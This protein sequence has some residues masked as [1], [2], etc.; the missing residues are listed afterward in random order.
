MN[1]VNLKVVILVVGLGMYMLLV[2]KVILKEMLLIVDKL[3][4]QYI[5]DEI[6]VVGIK[7]IVLVMYFLKNEVENYFDI[8]YELEVLLEQCVKCQLLVEV[9]VI[10]LLGVI[11]MNVCQ[12]QLLGL[13]YFIFCVCLVVG[14][15]LF[16][17]V[18]LDIIFDGGIVDLLCYNFVVMIVCFNEIGCSQVLVKCMLGDFFEY[19]VIQIKELMVV[20]GQVVCIVEFIEKLDELQILDFDLMVVGCYVL[21]VDIWVE[22][23]CIELGVWGCIQ[24]IDV[25]VELVKKQF[26]DVMLMIGES[27]DCGK[28]M[29]YM[30]VFVIY[31][32]CNLKEGIKFCESIKKMLV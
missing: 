25:I 14:D 6:V 23:E 15:N 29:G 18:L 26:V 10:C 22:L 8:F 11:I 4:I 28:K 24:L 21:L 5:V 2:I 27:Y 1:M 7:E 3:M 13:G 30:Q 9:Q 12:V 31:G 17:V 16:V 20:E 32:M 19:F